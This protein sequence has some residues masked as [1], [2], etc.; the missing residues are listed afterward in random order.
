MPRPRKKCCCRCYRADRVYKPQGVP[1]REIEPVLLSLDQFEAMRLCD[2]EGMDQE[3]AGT[4]MGVSRGTV[5]RLLYSGRRNLTGA[6]LSRQAIIIN[7][8]HN[9]AEDVSVHSKPGQGRARRS[10]E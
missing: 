4:K 2:V 8:K 6:I 1:M 7:L 9:E 3:Q 5:Q 10:G